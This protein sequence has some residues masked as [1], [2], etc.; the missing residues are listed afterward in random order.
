MHSIELVSSDHCQTVLPEIAKILVACVKQGASVGFV[1]PFD[2]NDSLEFW[3]GNVLPNVTNGNLLLLI[4]KHDDQ[5]T[6]CVY[7]DIGMM[8]NQVHRA[9][10]GK[11]LVDPNYRAKGIAKALMLEIEQQAISVNR[12]LLVLDTKTGDI[13]EQLYLS[14]GYQI[15]GCIPDFAKDPVGSNLAST[16][17]MYKTL[18]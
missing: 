6:G 16:T 17:Y 7:L 9:S 2:I 15:A 18:K 5:I 10:I 11:L 12:S 13:A 14:L 3:Q 1:E 4:A 8:P